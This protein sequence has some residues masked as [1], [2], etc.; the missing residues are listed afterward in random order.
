MFTAFALHALRDRL[1]FKRI[2]D[3]PRACDDGIPGNAGHLRHFLSYC[4][5]RQQMTVSKL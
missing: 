3:V 2:A 1:G 4:A 5:V